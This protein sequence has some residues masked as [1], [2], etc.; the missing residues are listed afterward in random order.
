[1][2]ELPPLPRPSNRMIIDS[3]KPLEPFY[4]ADQMRE[5]AA[6]AVAAERTANP[7]AL[8]R[9]NKKSDLISRLQDEADLCR[10][11]GA[12]DIAA[13]LDEAAAAV[14]AAIPEGWTVVPVEPTEATLAAGRAMLF[15]AS[16]GDL[17]ADDRE[18]RRTYSAMLGVAPEV[19]R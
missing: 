7:L 13:L 5:Y 1:M 11:E 2:N 19:P 16:G 17:E 10:N 6:A 3:F 4:T 12:D 15:S 18:M 14:A 8:N 9:A